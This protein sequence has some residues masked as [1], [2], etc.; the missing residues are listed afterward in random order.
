MS[1]YT[2]R[3]FRTR[4]GLNLY[5]RDYEGP[6]NARTPVLCLSGTGGNS[7]VYDDVA[8]HIAKKR[9]VLTMDWRGHGRSDRDPDWKHYHYEVDRDDVIEFLAALCLPKVI[10]VGTSLGG[11]VTMH[12][13]GHQPD[14]LAGSV[15]NDVGPIIGAVGRQRMHNNMGLQM[16][17][18]SFEEAAQ[19]LKDRAEPDFAFTPAEWMLRAKR[20]YFRDA[21]GKVKANMDPMYGRVFRERKRPPDW[22]NFW[23]GMLKIPVLAVRGGVSDTLDAATVAEMK[24]RKPDL[25]T[26]VVPGRGHCPMLTEPVARAAIDPFLASIP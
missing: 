10:T 1:V 23:E 21:D 11:I 7:A 2:E 5:F 25:Q 13:A 20:I 19:A 22:W 16:T 17:F 9:R 18:D 26:I 12:I 14:V 6:G 8:P 24:K 4:D 3:V 15:M